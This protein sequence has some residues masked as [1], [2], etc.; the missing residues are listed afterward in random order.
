MD[1]K[2]FKSP[3]PKQPESDENTVEE[4]GAVAVGNAPVDIVP[5]ETPK[6]IR[7]QTSNSLVKTLVMIG[8]ISVSLGLLAAFTFSVPLGIL[9]MAVGSAAIIA[10]VYLPIGS[11]HK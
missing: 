11:H 7:K 5:E 3:L 8:V 6:K 4:M 1:N 2:Q 10:C 9:L